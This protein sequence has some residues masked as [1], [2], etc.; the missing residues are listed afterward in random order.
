MTRAEGIDVNADGLRVTDGIGEL[1]F[2]T[3]G[4]TGGDDVFRDVAA[5]V[6]GGTVNLAR[7]FAGEGAASVTAHASVGVDDD[8]ASGE[9]AVTLGSADDEKTGRVD[10]VLGLGGK[11][12]AGDDRFDE[13]LF[14]DLANLGRR[15]AGGVLGRDDHGGDAGR[16]AVD[17]L[18][19]DLGLGVGAQPGVLTALA[20]I[21]DGATELVR[22]GDR[23]G[24]ERGSLAH[25][26]AEHDALITGALLGGL[27][28]VSGSGVDALGDVGGLL[29]DRV[30]E[31]EGVRIE[32]AVGIRVADL[33]HGGFDDLAVIELRTGRDLTAE[34][35]DVVFHHRFT[36][37][38]RSGVLLKTRI[39]DRVGDGVTYFVRVPFGH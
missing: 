10:V 31:E 16:F 38:P 6:G 23:G 21:G 27:F 15:D 29:A 32:F 4:E 20:E 37:D 18:H 19:R 14:Q 28:A 35:D 26:V 1:E 17:I 33:D 3:L 34:N 25:G 30:E 7:V 39:D 9:A 8:L 13:F 11:K 12:L 2:A 5:H 36:G 24:H 22:V